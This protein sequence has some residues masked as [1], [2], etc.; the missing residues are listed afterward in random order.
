MVG[1]WSEPSVDSA[2]SSCEGGGVDT[3]PSL[4]SGGSWPFRFSLRSF[5]VSNKVF[6][7]VD[8]NRQ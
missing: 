8:W 5:K 3:V 4:S 1:V 2:V 6:V 7:S